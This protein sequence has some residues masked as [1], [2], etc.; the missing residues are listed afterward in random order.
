MND[1]RLRKWLDGELPDSALS[2]KEICWLEQQVFN[3]INQKMLERPDKMTFAQH[4][5]LQ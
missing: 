5:V 2:C 4:D 1:E 3:A